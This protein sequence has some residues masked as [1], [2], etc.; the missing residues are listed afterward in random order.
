[1]LA[2]V[3]CAFF[4]EAKTDFSALQKQFLDYRKADKQDS[5]YR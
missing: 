2:F 4:S 3:F 5:A 1:M